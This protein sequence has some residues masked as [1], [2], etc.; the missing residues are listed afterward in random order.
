MGRESDLD[1]VPPL[2]EVDLLLLL[3]FRLQR[4]LMFVQPPTDGASVLGAKIKR[5]VLL[6]LVEE[7]ELLPLLGVVDSQRA[8]D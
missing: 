2:R 5:H 7:A 6:G 3:L 8:G 4:C 1:G